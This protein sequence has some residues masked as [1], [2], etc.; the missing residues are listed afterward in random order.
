MFIFFVTGFSKWAPN[1]YFDESLAGT[2]LS[3]FLTWNVFLS[4]AVS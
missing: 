4:Y 3:L 2:P 1:A